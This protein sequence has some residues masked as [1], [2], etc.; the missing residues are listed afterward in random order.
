MNQSMV[1]AT[2]LLEEPEV[3][4]VELFKTKCPFCKCISRG[5]GIMAMESPAFALK[6]VTEKKAIR[7]NRRN[8]RLAKELFL[9]KIFFIKMDF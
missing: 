8:E 4:L 6:A 3:I 1:F 5:L 7:Q 9:Q 2:S